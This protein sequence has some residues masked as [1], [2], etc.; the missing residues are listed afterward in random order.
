MES[1]LLFKDHLTVNIIV[2]HELI[3]GN[4]PQH[5]QYLNCNIFLLCVM[6]RP[7]RA[8]KQTKC[9]GHCPWCGDDAYALGLGVLKQ[10]AMIWAK[11]AQCHG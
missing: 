9:M 10:H 7:T 5:H 6:D 2:K 11:A 3:I 8:V 4:H 1:M